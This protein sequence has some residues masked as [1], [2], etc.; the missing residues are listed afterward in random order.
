MSVVVVTEIY[1]GERSSRAAQAAMARRAASMRS[2][3]GASCLNEAVETF[4]EGA[5]LV[6]SGRT[7][8][9]RTAML[10]GA[11]STPLGKSWTGIDPPGNTTNEERE[12]ARAMIS[13]RAWR[14]ADRLE[15]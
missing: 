15:P 11:R 4:E 10:S 12:I 7:I 9:L 8:S 5:V 1:P 6:R 13:V 3:S 2:L 14:N